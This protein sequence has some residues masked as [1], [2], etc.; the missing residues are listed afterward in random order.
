M[1]EEIDAIMFDL[2][3]T[4]IDLSPSREEIF[5]GVLASHGHRADP[6]KVAA[7]LAKADAV[8]DREFARLDGKDEERFWTRYDSMVLEELGAKVNLE[9]FAEDV[10]RAFE[11]VMG[12]V[13]SWVLYPEVR[14]VLE[15]LG[16]RD[17]AL[18][19]ISNATDLA[20]RVM[21]NLGLTELFDFVIISSEV[22]VSKPSPRIFQM[23]LE[24]AGTSPNRALYAGDRPELDVLPAFRV[25]LHAVLVDRMNAYPNCPCLRAR[26]LTF[27]NRFL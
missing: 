16:K 23:G 11:K 3:G 12:R 10:S 9:R 26:D 4:L 8:F 21:D 2:G 22:G 14:P 13:E 1:T 27:F 17:F 18:G 15:G 20:R 24:R 5:S 25:G 6:K 19:V 7:A